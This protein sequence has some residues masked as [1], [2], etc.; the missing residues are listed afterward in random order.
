MR[1][2]YGVQGTGQGHISRARSVARALTNFD[3]DVTWLFSGRDQNKLFGTEPFNKLQHR[4]GLT[5]VTNGGQLN[6]W[7]TAMGLAPLRLAKDV[8]NLDLDPYD[9]IV[10]DY[11]PITAWACKAKSRNCIGIGHQYAF[12]ATTPKTKGSFLQ[13]TIMNQFAPVD[14]PVGLHWAPFSNNILP[15]IL[16]LPDL[17][18]SNHAG[19]IIVYLPFES[20]ETITRWLQNFPEHQFIQYSLHCE[21]KKHGNVLTRKANVKS[22]KL[23]L[24]TSRAVI[25]N[26]G[27]ELISECLQWQKP[28]LTKPL[29]GQIEQQSNVLALT[30][31][32]YAESIKTLDTDRTLGW[33]NNTPTAPKV[34]YPDVAG[35]IAEWLVHG[36]REPVS[37]LS[38]RLWR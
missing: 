10:C 35:A 14:K 7:K 2:L 36:A 29:A 6:F 22:F 21:D 24:S 33:L 17:N 27:F 32:G 34:N 1:I 4:T 30:Y 23:D 5:F 28:V 3:I 26:S 15:P 31:L 9:L 38:K 8:A 16:D 20:Q 13:K 37:S 18:A 25:C 19:H 11:E 12:A